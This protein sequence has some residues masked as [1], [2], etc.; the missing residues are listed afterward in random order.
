MRNLMLVLVLVVVVSV[1][2]AGCF[3][4]SKTEVRPYART[5]KTPIGEDHRA[6]FELVNWF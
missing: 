2:L 6:G 4:D 1:G 3:E 5:V